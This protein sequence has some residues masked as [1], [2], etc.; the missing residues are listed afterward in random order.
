[1]EGNKK[2][3]PAELDNYITKQLHHFLD[4]FYINCLYRPV[5]I[6]GY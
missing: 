6:S 2:E 4:M 5:K 1:L 3:F